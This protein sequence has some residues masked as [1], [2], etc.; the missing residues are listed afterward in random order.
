MAIDANNSVRAA[1]KLFR[2]GSLGKF[3][4]D[5]KLITGFL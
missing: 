1:W 2:N 5:G 3:T 4:A